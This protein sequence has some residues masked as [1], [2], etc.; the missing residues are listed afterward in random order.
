MML[1]ALIRK[2]LRKLRQAPPERPWMRF[3]GL[4]Q[5]GDPNSSNSIDKYVYGR[6]D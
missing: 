3:A 5:S 4:V 6:K 1:I 2:L